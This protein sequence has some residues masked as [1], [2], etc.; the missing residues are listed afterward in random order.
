MITSL[1]G[2]RIIRQ[3]EGCSLQSYLCP[4]GV[5]TIGYGHTGPETKMGQKI[6]QHYA[7]E[8]LAFDLRKF[9]AAVA[10]ALT[11]PNAN[12]FS[13][14]VSLCFN[15]G[16]ANFRTSTLRTRFNAGLPVAAAEQFM[17]WNKA[18]VKG[19]LT[20]LPGLTKRREA[21]KALFLTAVS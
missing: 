11:N 1:E 13:A 17:R 9:E 2:Q 12:Q 14:C 8:I 6:S 5:P 21:E 20:V 10:L 4:A 19:V 15:I 7:D 16:V 3:F 18:T